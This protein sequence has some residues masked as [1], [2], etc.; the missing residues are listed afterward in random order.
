MC[1]TKFSAKEYYCSDDMSEHSDTES[2][3]DDESLDF[4]DRQDSNWEAREPVRITTQKLRRE[5]L[6]FDRISPYQTTSLKIQNETGIAHFSDWKQLICNK[7]I[8]SNLEQARTIAQREIQAAVKIQGV[9][10]KYQ[11]Y[12]KAF[13][14]SLPTE[15]LYGRRNRARKEREA[16]EDRKKRIQLLQREKRKNNKGLQFAHRRN[17]GGKRRPTQVQEGSTESKRLKQVVIDRRNQRRRAKKALKKS[18][19]QQPQVQT[20][21]V[22]EEPTPEVPE[23]LIVSDSEELTEQELAEKEAIERQEQLAIDKKTRKLAVQDAFEH[24]IKVRMSKLKFDALVRKPSRVIRI[25]PEHKP[26]VVKPQQK[27]KLELIAIVTPILQRQLDKQAALAKMAD[28]KSMGKSLKKTKM[29]KS[30]LAGRKCT[31]GKTC[32]FAHS[33]QELC[34]ADCFFKESCKKH[35]C[36]FLHPGETKA[37]CIKRLRPDKTQEKPKNNQTQPKPKNNQTQPKPKN[38][39]RPICRSVGSGKPCYHGRRCKFQHISERTN[40]KGLTTFFVAKELK[41]QVQEYIKIHRLKAQITL[42]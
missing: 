31:Y 11:D 42:V 24:F 8:Q 21:P 6:D 34:I 18:T 7:F 29:C 19:E 30:V 10:R 41:P 38:S 23:E 17:G 37:T 40:S 25:V 12:W 4:Y 15:S 2:Q 22:Q 27:P 16:N 35:N 1:N 20:V 28:R 32:H 14:A 9:V 36:P 39:P 3:F 13:I 5:D 33:E 26:K